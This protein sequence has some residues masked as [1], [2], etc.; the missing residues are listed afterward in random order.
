M[1]DKP[2]GVLLPKQTFSLNERKSALKEM[3]PSLI[4]KR[5]LIIDYYNAQQNIKTMIFERLE[6]MECEMKPHPVYSPDTAP[7]GY[8]LFHIHHVPLEGKI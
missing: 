5:K 4:S 2:H 8:N 1:K 7:A 6:Q 3:Q